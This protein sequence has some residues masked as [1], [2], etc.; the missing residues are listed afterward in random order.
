MRAGGTQGLREEGKT[1]LKTKQSVPSC[2]NL[3]YKAGEVVGKSCG[4]PEGFAETPN[5]HGAV[6]HSPR[7]RWAPPEPKATGR[8]AHQP[9]HQPQRAQSLPVVPSIPGFPGEVRAPPAAPGGPQRCPEEP[10][11]AEHCAP[12]PPLPGSVLG[13]L[14]PF[15]ETRRETR[16]PTQSGAQNGAPGAA[17]PSRA[18]SLREGG[19]GGGGAAQ[20]P[21]SFGMGRSGTSVTS[22]G[23]WGTRGG[24]ALPAP[25]GLGKEG[26]R[27]GRPVTVGVPRAGGRAANRAVAAPKRGH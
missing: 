18:A 5:A 1:E 14:R 26:G 11:R 15:L 21:P 12:P 23:L 2:P 9:H 19:R 20:R 22:M 7:P 10:R 16:S 27:K 24:T 17:M 3:A 13:F 6:P 8:A 4:A 25:E